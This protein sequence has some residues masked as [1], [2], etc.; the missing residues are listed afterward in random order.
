[1][2]PHQVRG[3]ARSL[4]GARGACATH[5]A[6]GNRDEG[7]NDNHHESAMEREANAFDGNV[8][9]VGG[10]PPT[11]ISSTEFMQGVFTAI[12]QVVRNTV[13]E[14]LVP[15]RTVDTRAVI[16]E[17]VNET[18]RIT[19]P[20]SQREGT[21]EQS[22]GHFSKKSKSSMLLHQTSRGGPI[23]F[24]CHQSGH[25]VAG[26]PLKGQKRQSR[27]GGYSRGLAQEQLHVRKPPTCFHCDQVGHI[28]R[29][30]IQ[31]RNTQGALGQNGQRTQ[32]RAYAVTSAVGPS[33][34]AGQQEQ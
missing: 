18:R 15:A 5:G 25:R 26:C 28:A 13:Q 10:A 6:R 12:E 1:M 32:G 9:V 20:K 21:S 19:H 14:M 24:G 7:D 2:P 30:C 4:T 34:T 16:K 17:G 11:V 3:C 29:Q 27:Q 31:K 23:C 33:E 22:E 8:W